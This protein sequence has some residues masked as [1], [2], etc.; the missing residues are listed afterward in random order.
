LA[1]IVHETGRPA[2]IDDSSDVAKTAPVLE[3]RSSLGA[4]ITLEGRLW[5]LLV[6]GIG[7]AE[8]APPG[9]EHRLAGFAELVATAIANAEAQAELTSSRARIVAAA[10]ET[11]RQIERDLHDG[12]Q[13][14]L[15]FRLGYSC[16]QPRLRC[17]PNSRRLSAELAQIGSGLNAALEELR[18]LSQGIHPAILSEAG[19]APSLRALA[20]RSAIPVEVE[21]R[22]ATLMI[23]VS[24]DGVGGATFVG[25][26]GLVGLRDRVGALGGRLERRS[27]DG[28]GTSLSVE[29]PLG[30]DAAAAVSE[31]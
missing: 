3:I 10:D 25:G 15:V 4:P 9:T 16:V 30:E 2:R 21:A 26:S 12:A 23:S 11:R 17:R 24:D 29:L 22:G 8:P 19:L 13:Q 5:G 18:Q 31:E 1:R 14:R 20:R 28:A 7:G 27:A 6:A